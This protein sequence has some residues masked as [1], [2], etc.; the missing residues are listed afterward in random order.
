ML[1]FL[2]ITVSAFSKRRFPFSHSLQM[3]TSTRLPVVLPIVLN[4]VVH[5]PLLKLHYLSFAF[6]LLSPPDLHSLRNR[7][8]Y[9]LL[10]LSLLR[11]TSLITPNHN[12]TAVHNCSSFLV[13]KRRAHDKS[14]QNIA[15][16]IY[17]FHFFP[18]SFVFMSSIF[19][20]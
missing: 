8:Q 12:K 19:S 13:W 6:Q 4:Q 14:T 2:K 5:V 17:C 16:L 3:A 11:V 1:I 7:P 18:W 9:C 15:S 10:H 20:T